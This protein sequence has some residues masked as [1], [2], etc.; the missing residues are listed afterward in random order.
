MYLQCEQ[1]KTQS[2]CGENRIMFSPCT[3]S[4]SRICI[5]CPKY[6]GAESTLKFQISSV[7]FVL[8]FPDSHKPLYSCS[9]SHKPLYSCSQT[10]IEDCW[11][12]EPLYRPDFPELSKELHKNVSCRHPSTHTHT[13]THTHTPLVPWIHAADTASQN[14]YLFHSGR[15]Q[16]LSHW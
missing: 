10:L 8:L 16:R 11:S 13:H 12:H 2:T 4:V 7:V 9:H 5:V 3:C 1:N 14:C 15:G 6:T